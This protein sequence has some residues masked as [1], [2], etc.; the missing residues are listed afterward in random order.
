M[1]LSA[2]LGH[3]DP[4]NDTKQFNNLTEEEQEVLLTW[5]KNNFMPIKCFTVNH[6]SY[7]LKHLFENSD[8]GFYI[9]NGAFK[10][11][12]VKCGYKAE[13]ENAVN[14]YFN[15]SKKSPALKPWKY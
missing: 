13:D 5:V 7:A 1:S 3:N 4:Y 6:S 11:A 2:M 8:E 9:P 12:M 15:I 14:W 10:A